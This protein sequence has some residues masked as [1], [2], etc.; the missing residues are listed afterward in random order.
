MTVCTGCSW[1]SKGFRGRCVERGKERSGFLRSFMCCIIEN[2]LI[3]SRWYFGPNITNM[4]IVDKLLK[5]LT[6]LTAG[7]WASPH[8]TLNISHTVAFCISMLVFTCVRQI[9]V[10]KKPPHNGI[11]WK[12]HHKWPIENPR[13]A[14]HET[15]LDFGSINKYA[16][17][18][19]LCRMLFFWVI[20]QRL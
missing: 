5:V 14:V 9:S 19:V 2:E 15:F 18:V 13:F 7:W 10:V 16:K 6:L 12:L 1:I 20:H 17:L 3:G 11:L 8:Q 4:D